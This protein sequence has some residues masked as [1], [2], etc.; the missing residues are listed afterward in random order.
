MAKVFFAMTDVLVNG[1]GTGKMAE[2]LAIPEVGG[3]SDS[4][5]TGK[6]RWY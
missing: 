5:G 6:W 4:K 1:R 2:V 3:A